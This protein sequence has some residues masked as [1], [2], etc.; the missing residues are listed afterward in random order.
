VDD[1]KCRRPDISRARELLSWEP[2]VSLE[3]GLE[4]TIDYFGR[5]QDVAT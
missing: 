4:Q 2:R 5:L 3:E 1:P